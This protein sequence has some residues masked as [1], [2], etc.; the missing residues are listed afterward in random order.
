MSAIGKG[1]WVECVSYD[2]GHPHPAR[3]V[4]TLTVGGIYRVRKVVR[5]RDSVRGVPADGIQVDG[6]Y[7]YHANGVEGAWHPD[8]FRPI[9]RPRAD[10]IESLL[11]PLSE[12]VLEQA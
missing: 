5:G 12:H 11:Q 3:M 9:Y 8:R 2:G 6:V 4:G 1:D 7:A 10:L